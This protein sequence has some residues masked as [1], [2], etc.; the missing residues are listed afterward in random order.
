VATRTLNVR[1]TGD[2]RGFG[3]AMKD[4]TRDST[5]AERVLKHLGIA[6][7]GSDHALKGLRVSAFGV[8]GSFAKIGTIA[9][10]VTPAVVAL[11][12]AATALAGSLTAAA[13]GAAAL[14][15]GLG[16]SLAPILVVGK[17][18]TSRFEEITKAYDALKTA[19]KEGTEASRKNAEQAMQDLSKAERAFVQTLERVSG[20]QRRVLGGASDRIFTALGGA[21]RTLAPMLESLEK[22]FDRL[23]DAIGRVITKA[24][25]SLSGPEWR[26]A[27]TAFIDSARALVEPVSRIFGSIANIMRDVALASLPILR[28]GFQDLARWFNRLDETATR[29]AIRDVVRDL[30]RHTKSWWNLTK[31]VGRLIFNIFNGGA[32]AGKNLVD[33]LT[34]IVRQWNRFLETREGQREMRRFFRDAVQATKDLFVV[35]GA[36][37]GGILKV[38]RVL[39]NLNQYIQTAERWIEK[40]DRAAIKFAG[41]LTNALSG[42]ARTAAGAVRV[43]WNRV[44]DF[45]G[46]A[47][48]LGGKIIGGIVEGLASLPGRVKSAL[49]SGVEKGIRA[50][51]GPIQDAAGWIGDKI[52][53][54]AGRAA[55]RMGEGIGRTSIPGLGGPAGKGA[56]MGADQDLAPFAAMGA[57]FGLSTSSGIRPGAVTSSGNQSYHATG[58][59]LDMIGPPGRML[60]FFQFM[61]ERFG[62]RLA[63]LIYTPGG[64]GINDGR[65]Y[66]YGG[67]VAADH[68]DHVHLAYTGKAFGD[69]IGRIA[70]TGDGPGKAK[71]RA[72]AEAAQ[73][74]GISPA[75]LWGVYG[76]E[77]NFGRIKSNSPAGAQGPFQFM[78]ATARAYGVNPHNFFSAVRGAAKYLSQYKSRGV[79]GMIAA[80][81][82]GPAG[83]PNNSE[84]RAYIPKVIRLAK[85]WPGVGSRGGGG[86]SGGGGGGGSQMGP[87]GLDFL[88]AAESKAQLTPGVRDD[89]KVYNRAVGYWERRLERAE[90]SKDPRRIR[91]AA[92]GLKSA[93]ENRPEPVEK[94]YGPGSMGGI[95]QQTATAERFTAFAQRSN[96]IQLYILALK[97]ERQLKRRR[98]NRLKKLL[99][100]RLTASVRS[101]TISELTTLEAEIAEITATIKEFKADVKGGAQTIEDAEGMEAGVDPDAATP[102]DF[103]EAALAQAELTPGTADDQA[104]LQNILG[105]RQGEYSAA[106]ASGDPR[107]ISEAARNLKAAQDALGSMADSMNQVAETMKNLTDEMSRTRKFNEWMATTQKDAVMAA[108]LAY[109]NGSIGERAGLGMQGIRSTAGSMAGL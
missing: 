81:N 48:R 93:R 30:V 19:Q 61:R 109:F 53:D 5:A 77:T 40:A 10:A 13:G 45:A 59:A 26:G 84:T 38:S 65:P 88:E 72:I 49:V 32:D 91:E 64:I 102:M 104:A 1:I 105:I 15:T 41:V 7:D 51:L 20:L 43:L 16:A 90:K 70:R 14:G 56:L 55:R 50:A 23:G 2:S 94:R 4:V 11:G 76:A 34:R 98:V 12:G 25:R 68:Y 69:G 29:G 39:M 57:K 101:Q 33:S 17:Q 8:S 28:S 58:D 71:I 42:A 86:G 96:N 108:V 80:Y 82:A 22:P 3:R 100:R 31:E 18:V 79:A 9:T 36:L 99:K 92:Q 21:I 63:E 67:Q 24:S 95:E 89:M 83:N 35:L 54:G 47:A 27:F 74:Y 107:R 46:D 66:T 97:K 62:S 78:P 75:I 60:K 37:A 87:T 52:G 44:G 103:A 85:S 6:A 106:V 73:R